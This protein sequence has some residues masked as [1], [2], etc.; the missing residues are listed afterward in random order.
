MPRMPPSE[1]MSET[2]TPPGSRRWQRPGLGAVMEP[3]AI[4]LIALIISGVSFGLAL[5]RASDDG[6][7]H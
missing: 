7:D 3:A 2:T 4:G 1:P 6:Q 5:A